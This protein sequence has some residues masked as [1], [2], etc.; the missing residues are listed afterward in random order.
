MKKTKWIL[1]A[2]T[3]A[4][5]FV[6]LWQINH[7]ATQIRQSEQA[8]VRIWANAIGQKMELVNHT[9]RFF[10]QVTLDEHRKMQ[11]YTNILQSFNNSDANLDLSFSLAYVNYIVDSSHTQLIITDKDSIITTPRELSG[12]KLNGDLLK[13]FSQN[14]PFHYRI[15]GMPMTLYYKESLIYSDMR[16]MLTSLNTS[17]LEDIT[18]NSV[19]VPVIIVD[20]K[21]KSLISSGNIQEKE[22]DTPM[23]LQAKLDDMASENTPIQITLPNNQKAL[24]YYEQTP[25]QHSLRWVP[26]LYMFIAFVIMIVSYYLFRTAKT[27]E[28][29]RIWI[30]MAKETA[31]Q[32][33]T[34]ISSLIAWTEYL[35]NK[36]FEEKYAAEVRK[37]ISR[38][39]TITHRFSKIGSVPEL[40]DADVVTTTNNA[41]TYL[42]GRAPR[43]IQF[44]TNFPDEP[45]SCPLNPYLFE[46]VI[47]NI[48]KNA[49][50]AMNGN[51]TFSVIISSDSKHI[52]I[53]LCDTGKGIPNSLHKK[54][55]DSGFTTKQRGWGL[56]L[57]LAKRI[58][59]EYHRG[60]IFVKYSVPGQGTVFRIVLN[61]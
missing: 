38:L 19:F 20:E 21:D 53:D 13:E 40:V 46:W 52:Y 14:P 5:A 33:G 2:I 30:G 17:F 26:L 23:K 60:K 42:K 57:S 45:L 54:V 50:D 39:E 56:G 12:K 6:A 22:F 51:G 59:E 8:K 24:V 7:I 61:K 36:T 43:K 55:F 9:E 18:N 41:I 15:W 49:I 48:C 4:L 1:L 34:P 31:H 35:Q 27:M 29:N 3:V 10:E 28:Q 58:I 16:E 32:L 11:L 25:L 44:V 47:E 37:D